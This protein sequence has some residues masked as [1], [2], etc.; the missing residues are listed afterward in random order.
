MMVEELLMQ[1]STYKALVTK[2]SR[3]LSCLIKEG[4]IN[5]IKKHGVM[6]KA[7]FHSFDDVCETYLEMLTDETD[8]TDAESYY[9]AVYDD[10]MD[11][12]DSLNYAMDSFTMQAP[13]VVQRTDSNTTL[14]TMSPINLPKMVREQETKSPIQPVQ[15][16][17]QNNETVLIN[18]HNCTC[19]PL[20]SQQ[21]QEYMSTELVHLS[22][23]VHDCTSTNCDQSLLDLHSDVKP[24]SQVSVVTVTKEELPNLVDCGIPVIN[25][26]SPIS[27]DPPIAQTDLHVQ[28]PTPCAQYSHTR[29]ATIHPASVMP[30]AAQ[31]SNGRSADHHIL[32]VPSQDQ[33]ELKGSYIPSQTPR[34]GRKVKDGTLHITSTPRLAACHI[35]SGVSLLRFL[36]V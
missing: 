30:S 34:P 12:L 33:L 11:Q 14:S 17:V 25:Q 13:A 24:Q 16:V 22:T 20:P 21:V 9:D 27:L 29:H 7:W 2:S 18:T 26:S 10:Y 1:R 28:T 6:M 31:L 32:T 3:T 5:L 23:C 19:Q 4:D 8:I 35:L 15:S 36:S